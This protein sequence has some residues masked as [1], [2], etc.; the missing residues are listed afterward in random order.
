[1]MSTEVKAA[2]G[3]VGLCAAYWASRPVSVVQAASDAPR[4][5]RRT[6]W[7]A[8]FEGHEGAEPSVD[9]MV[10]ESVAAVNKGAAT[11]LKRRPSWEAKFVGHEDPAVVDMV[12]RAGE[13]AQKMGE[14]TSTP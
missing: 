9:Q 11:R 1:M 4:L 3:A 14:A 8:K 12:R 2:L 6:S 10:K 13:G 5:K 7:E